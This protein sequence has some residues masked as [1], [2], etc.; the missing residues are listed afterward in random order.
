MMNN[1]T[2]INDK[3]EYCLWRMYIKVNKMYKTSCGE[4]HVQFNAVSTGNCHKFC[5]YCGKLIKE[6]KHE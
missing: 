1:K 3:T 5:P 4:M 6:M 2:E